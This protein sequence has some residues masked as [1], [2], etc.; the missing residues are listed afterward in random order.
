M[1]KIALLPFLLIPALAGAQP[2]ESP[3]MVAKRLKAQCAAMAPKARVECE[4]KAR[5]ETRASID[6]HHTQKGTVAGKP[7]ANALATGFRETER[8]GVRMSVSPRTPQK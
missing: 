1:K 4:K 2:Y 8:Q 3:A 7:A 5:A 6:R